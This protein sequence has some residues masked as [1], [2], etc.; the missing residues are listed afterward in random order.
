MNKKALIVDDSPEILEIIQEY[1][2]E[3]GIDSIKAAD[4]KEALNKIKNDSFD[5]V[6]TDVVMPELNGLELTR[7]VRRDHPQIKIMAISGGGNSGK[8]VASLALDQVLSEG[9][10]SALMKPFSEEDFKRK[11]LFLMEKI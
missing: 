5:I 1:L 10:H 9:A 7:T 3:L 8:L 2:S 11:V 4:G 6:I